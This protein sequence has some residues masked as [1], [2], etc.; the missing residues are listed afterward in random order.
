VLS[1]LSSPT[2]SPARSAGFQ[3]AVSRKCILQSVGYLDARGPCWRPAYDKSA[4]EQIE[5]LRYVPGL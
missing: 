5:N 2:E 4:L 3:S 1:I